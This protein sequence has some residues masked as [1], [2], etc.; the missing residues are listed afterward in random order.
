MKKIL[1]T[2]LALSIPITVFGSVQTL[3]WWHDSSGF[4]YPYLDT[5]Y[6][7][8][9][10][11]VATS[12]TATSTFNGKIQANDDIYGSNGNSISVG[13]D[14]VANGLIVNMN[15]SQNQIFFSWLGNSVKQYLTSS[16]SVNQGG[17]FDYNTLGTK[18]FTI[19]NTENA[20]LIFGAGDVEKMRILDT[21]NIGIGTTTPY[22]KLSVWGAGTGTSRLFE[23][24]N[25][26]STTLASFL[27]NGTGYFLGNIGVG[28]TSPFAKLAINPVTGD[29]NSFVIGSSTATKFVVNNSGNVGVG[30]DIPTAMVDTVSTSGFPKTMIGFRRPG[31]GSW[32]IMLGSE[33]ISNVYIGLAGSVTNYFWRANWNTAN[34]A[35]NTFQVAQNSDN[36]LTAVEILQQRAGNTGDYLHITSNGGTT[37]NILNVAN[38]KFIGIG[39]TTPQW[40]LTIASSTAPQ[41]SL[42]AGAGIPQWTFRNAGGNLYIST[43]TVAGTA[44]T[45]I[46]ALKIDGT[47]GMTSFHQPLAQLSSGVS[48][49]C[50]NINT[51]Y[52]LTFD[53][54]DYINTGITHSTTVNNATTTINYAGT[55]EI[56]FST[57]VSTDA[58]TG[59][60]GIW[61]NVNNTN[62]A[63]SSTYVELPTTAESIITAPIIYSFSANDQFQL[64][65]ACD[66]AGS[67]TVSTASGGLGGVMPVSPSTIMTI[68]RISQ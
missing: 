41:L 14:G 67:Y 43:T 50:T 21:G 28:T 59:H 31:L 40:P 60:M 62:V 46:W 42:S 58:G 35:G 26:A 18:E 8:V 38:S 55:Y 64:R 68:K 47:T 2:V 11:I 12:T 63:S 30:I 37:G 25:S 5:D 15:N 49:V 9:P 48:Q 1:F 65:M 36:S 27:E 66:N 45:S 57:I 19:K 56:V 33:A 13:E 6:I 54:N 52:P 20:P 61:L 4:S 3:P 29:Q 53:Y 39:T 17:S 10:Y 22:S 44:T 16:A 7:K 51:A 34:V 23:L 32:G 24:T